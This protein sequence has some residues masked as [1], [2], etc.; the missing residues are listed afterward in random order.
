LN[1][2]EDF[3]YV[4][5]L[6]FLDQYFKVV[7]LKIVLMFRNAKTCGAVKHC[8]QTVW[9]HQQLPPDDD[10]VC[11]ICLDMVKQA[12]DQLE[13]NETQVKLNSSSNVQY[14]LQ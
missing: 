13:S 7:L 9:E 2:Q 4:L 1:L 8:I 3:W 5:T 12:R 10:D 11:Q 14:I 6:Q